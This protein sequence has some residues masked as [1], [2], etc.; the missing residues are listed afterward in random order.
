MGSPAPGSGNAGDVPV[1]AG[2]TH[3]LLPFESA[4]TPSAPGSRLGMSPPFRAGSVG[5]KFGVIIALSFHGS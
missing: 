3:A 4:E 1:V 2:A 5:V